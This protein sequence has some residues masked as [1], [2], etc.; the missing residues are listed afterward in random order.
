MMCSCDWEN[1]KLPRHHDI[2]SEVIKRGG[3]KNVAGRL[4]AGAPAGPPEL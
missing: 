3:L 2:Q 1:P 4:R